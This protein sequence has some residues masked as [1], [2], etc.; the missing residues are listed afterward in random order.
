MRGV[1][2]G[3]NVLRVGRAKPGDVDDGRLVPGQGEVRVPT[4]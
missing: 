4:I 2:G 3:V 1:G